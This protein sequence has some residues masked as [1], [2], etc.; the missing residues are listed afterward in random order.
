VTLIAGQNRAASL[1]VDS[2]YFYWANSYSIGTISRC[3]LQGCVGAPTV[4]I[5][6]QARPGDLVVDGRSMAWMNVDGDYVGVEGSASRAK[7][8]RCPVDGCEVGMHT[9]ADQIGGTSMIGD[10]SHLCWIA[11]GP[12]GPFPYTD[13]PQATIY[14]HPK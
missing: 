5:A 1:A 13:F 6:G 4:L 10:S 2:E 9:L 12:L 14:R 7:V 3:P 11:L 8:M